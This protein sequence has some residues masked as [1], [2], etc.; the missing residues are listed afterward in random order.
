M[1][2]RI[3]NGKAY[4]EITGRLCDVVKGKVPEKWEGCV[5]NCDRPIM[6]H[7]EDRAEMSMNRYPEPW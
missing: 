4:C 2:L 3:S 1:Y 7:M 6:K 5:C